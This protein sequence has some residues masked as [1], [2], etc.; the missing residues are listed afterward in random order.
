MANNSL[1]DDVGAIFVSFLGLTLLLIALVF[2]FWIAVPVAIILCIYAGYR[3]H[4]N[5]DAV[6]ERKAH[7]LTHRLYAET[8]ALAPKI[9]EKDDFA[10]Q[11]YGA[12]PR[13]ASDSLEDALIVATLD[14]FDLEGFDVEGPHPPP[15]VCNSIEAARYR[16]YLAEYGRRASVPGISDLAA[17]SIIDSNR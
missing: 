2:A 7:A 1:E 12:I 15:T 3:M 13:V 6:K 14:L 8:K 17:D 16:D 9:P 10:R 5:S 4:Q 11:V